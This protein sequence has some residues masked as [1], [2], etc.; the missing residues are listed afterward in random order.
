MKWAGHPRVA[1]ALTA[2]IAAFTAAACFGGPPPPPPPPSAQPCQ[3]AGAA[4]TSAGKGEPARAPSDQPIPPDE[5]G[6]QAREVA[7]TTDVRTKNGDI[8][9]VT[10]EERGGKPEITSTPVRSPDEAA[11]VAEQKAADGDLH[12]VDVDKP[13]KASSFSTPTDPSFGQQWSFNEVPY[14]NA[15]NTDNT[16]GF[17]VTIADVDTGVMANHP[18]LSGQV[19]DGHFFLHDNGGSS[20]FEGDGGTTD[21]SGHGTHVSGTIAALSSNGAGVSGAAPDA[22]ILPV[23]VLCG[24]GT[25]FS[26]DVA[27]GIT[28]AVD[29]G[30]KV[31]NLSLGGPAD[32]S[33]LSAVQYADSHD[34]VVV[35]AGG[36][37]GTNGPASYP[38]A[39]STS[40]G[41]VI[42][43]AA[44]TN[45]NPPGHPSYG[46]SGSHAG[47]LD[48]SAPGGLPSSNDPA[49]S[50]LSTW[51]DGGYNSIAGTSMATPHVSAAVALLRAA[52]GACTDSQVKSRLK[53]TATDLGVVGPDNTFGAGLVDPNAAGATC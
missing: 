10:V 22:K 21:P 18:D 30:A 6:A 24:D 49:V 11:S 47:Y 14:V 7:S 52:N 46:T 8:P 13:V 42:A 51:N 3:S 32:A 50:V 15:W 37:D 27:N 28:W 39:Y 41:N 38:A 35:A 20:S 31:V 25:G 36:N 44:T 26:S 33:E 16:R 23:Q 4:S 53:T 19:L 40:Q 12:A 5:A 9:L 43:V 17:G 48:L 45:A 29:H 34:V 1:L 2:S